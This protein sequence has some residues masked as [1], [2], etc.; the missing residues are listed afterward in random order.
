MKTF[1]MS[2][3][4]RLISFAVITVLLVA[5]VGFAVNGKQNEEQ[6][7]T[8]GDSNLENNNESNIPTNGTLDDNSPPKF[9]STATGLPISEENFNSGVIGYVTSPE[10]TMYGMSL[11]DISLEFGTEDGAS[12]M[13]S[14]IQGNASLWKIGSLLPTRDYIS[15]MTAFFGG[16]IFSAGNDDLLKYSAFDA[17][18]KVISVTDYKE[19]YYTENGINIYTGKDMINRAFESAGLLNQIP[20]GNMPFLFRDTEDSFVGHADAVNILIPFSK[21]NSTVLKYSQETNKYS[22]YK[23]DTKKCDMLTGNSVEYTN[24]FILFADTVTYEMS[25][26]SELVYDT[27]GTG[28]GFYISNGKIMEIKW[29]VT[30]DGNLIFNKLNGEQLEITCG[31][32]YIAYYKTSMSDEIAYN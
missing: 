13:V 8:T 23:N 5:I 28:S 17:Q 10:K 22:Y 2:N 29:N 24:V 14:Y 12:R 30:N 11:A 1:K 15:S 16:M 25:E 3:L 7:P 18:N 32:S 27:L 9:I 31:N 20:Y 26:G 19:C 21:T 4:T 6:E